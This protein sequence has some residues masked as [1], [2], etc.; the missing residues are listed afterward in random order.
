MTQVDSSVTQRSDGR[1]PY[2]YERFTT[3]LMLADLR[4]TRHAPRP[5]DPVPA[6]D[7]ATV[8]GGRLRSA[9]LLG[10]KPFIVTLGSLTCP[11]TAAAAHGLRQLHAATGDAVELITVYTREAHPGESIPQPARLGQ[12]LEHAQALAER[13][14]YHWTVA[15][16]DIDGTLHRQ[17]DLKPNAAYLVDRSGRIAF[18][19][20]WSSETAALITAAQAVVRG[21]RP[22]H[23]TNSALL[24]PMMRAL[25]L[26][27]AVMR[28]A[29]RRASRDL[30]RAAAPMA[31]MA[32]LARPWS[33]L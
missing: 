8:D 33:R 31:L 24:R 19:A 30:W 3:R 18:R 15:V 12:K 23:D 22:R 2:R 6:F 25:P 10:H 28:R 1:D 11:M 9:D 13:D 21:D 7:L 29:G 27:D 32:K 5:G 17:L 26:V 20:L 4:F 14:Y 16:D